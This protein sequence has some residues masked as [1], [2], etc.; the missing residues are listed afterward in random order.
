MQAFTLMPMSKEISLQPGE[1]YRGSITISNPAD[2]ESDFHYFVDVTPYSV[3][4]EEYTVDFETKSDWSKIVDWITVEEPTGTI[5]PNGQKEVFYTVNVPADA[6]AGGQYA[7]LEVKT[8]E[9]ASGDDSTSIRNIFGMG[10]ILYAH[11]AGETTH[12]GEILTNSIPGFVTN[13]QPVVSAYI[14]NAGNVHE[15]ARMTLTVKNSLTGEMVFPVGDE[16]NVFNE[17]IMP[18]TTRYITR[19]LSSLSPLGV[20]EV[21]Q[22]IAYIGDSELAHNSKIMIMC[23]LWFLVLV[24]LT[25]GALIGGV[26]G[27]IHKHRKKRRMI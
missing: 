1:V 21:T 5:A 18:D 4:G 19:K 26:V 8:D 25:V 3:A 16:T 11:V 13:G 6:P 7:M 2:A 15:I 27:I 14:N 22:D 20:F 23:P 9:S 12:E 17:I 10:S 24:I